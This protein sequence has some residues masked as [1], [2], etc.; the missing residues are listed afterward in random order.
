MEF[1]RT[2]FDAKMWDSLVLLAAKE[3]IIT[4]IEGDT[5]DNDFVFKETKGKR[6]ANKTEILRLITLFDKVECLDH[7]YDLS[8]LIS[9]GLLD[10]NYSIL[11]QFEKLHPNNTIPKD[12]KEKM[13][14]EYIKEQ[15]IEIMIA[16]KKHIITHLRNTYELKHF[17]KQELLFSFNESM[18]FYINFEE[19]HIDVADPLFEDNLDWFFRS[20]FV[21]IY[22]SMEEN[23][24]Y[25]SSFKFETKS[26]I[27]APKKIIDEVYYTAK[28]NFTDEIIYLPQPK[29]LKEALRIRNKK[30]I[31]R[32]REIFSNWT[33]VVKEGNEKLEIKIR[34]D[35]KKANREMNRLESIRE[36]SKSPLN[37]WI[38]AIGGH[39]PVLSNILTATSMFAGIYEKHSEKKNSWVLLGK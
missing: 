9:E 36:F 32:F 13:L 21:G 29:T 26:N 25:S 31:V 11:Y 14:L 27:I 30:E 15:T 4:R 10:D 39:I 37:F 8:N 3:K 38:N 5:E 24:I 17:S 35:I 23:A 1:N 33:Q 12:S 18:K 20:I 2:Y 19:Y 16:S 6:V 28:T 34:K 7:S 22:K